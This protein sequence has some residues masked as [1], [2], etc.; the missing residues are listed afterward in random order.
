MAAQNAP[1]PVQPN[2]HL[3][4]AENAWDPFTQTTCLALGRTGS[5]TAHVGDM[6]E[7]D[8][9]YLEI[10]GCPP[11]VQASVTDGGSVVASAMGRLPIDEGDI[12]RKATGFF[13][14]AVR[15]GSDTITLTAD[16]QLYT[17][18]IDVIDP[19]AEDLGHLD[20]ESCTG[21][22]PVPGK[23][24][25]PWISAG[26]GQCFTIPRPY[27]FTVAVGDLIEMDCYSPTTMTCLFHPK[28]GL[29]GDGSVAAS[30]LGCRD[31]RRYGT[32]GVAVHAASFFEAVRLGKS[33][34]TFK[35]KG[36]QYQYVIKV[37]AP[38][39]ASAETYQDAADGGDPSE[40]TPA[41]NSPLELS[42][43]ETGEPE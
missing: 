31:M 37:K 13:F 8:F 18:R 21:N 28:I 7:V 4:R 1:L 39:Q 41:K 38:A 42:G 35:V 3:V 27:H 25:R 17:Y 36:R 5:Y 24:L 9:R 34:I 19:L 40:T 16:G 22:L 23:L 29:S 32:Y 15:A 10:P 26:P 43:Q 6:V 2:G 33:T 20:P 14:D 30:P 11:D 12:G